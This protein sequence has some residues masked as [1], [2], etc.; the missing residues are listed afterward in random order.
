MQTRGP[1]LVVARLQRHQPN[2]TDL[3]SGRA[4]LVRLDD[5]VVVADPFPVSPA[6]TTDKPARP[7]D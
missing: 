4:S 3:H 5:I 6:L 1:W 2:T 7:I